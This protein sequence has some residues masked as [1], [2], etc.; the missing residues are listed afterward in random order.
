MTELSRR[1]VVAGAGAAGAWFA[2]G[3]QPATAGTAPAGKQVPSFYR[4]KLGD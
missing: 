3:A 1:S 4:S 2:L